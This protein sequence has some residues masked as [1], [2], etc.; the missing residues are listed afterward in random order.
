MEAQQDFKELLALFNTH[1]VA[2]VIVG[3]Y[4]L[5]YHGAPRYTGDLDLLI[6]PNPEN[7]QRIL[8]ALSEFGFGNLELTATDFTTLDNVIQLGYPPVRIDLVTSITGVSWEDVEKNKETGT[9][10]E[11]EVFYIGRSQLVENKRLTGRRKD[12]ADLEALGEE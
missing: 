11:V 12:L 3:A 6:Q 9:Y 4:A 5:S 8:T 1:N 10:G 7:A 2:Y